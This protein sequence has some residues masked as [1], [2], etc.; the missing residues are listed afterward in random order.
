MAMLNMLPGNVPDVVA[1][2][3]SLALPAGLSTAEAQTLVPLLPSSEICS[4][5]EGLCSNSVPIPGRGSTV[6]A[7]TGGPSG[8][9]LPPSSSSF[10]LAAKTFFQSSS[11]AFSDLGKNHFIISPQNNS[12]NLNSAR[13]TD[14]RNMEELHRRVA[15]LSVN[16]PKGIC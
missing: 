9:S 11:K 4:M 5:P 1:G 14:S 8:F 10:F 12:W 3:C 15:V 7:N 2:A 16:Q 13:L 6:I